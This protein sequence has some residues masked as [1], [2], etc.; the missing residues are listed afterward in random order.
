MSFYDIGQQTQ[1][2]LHPFVLDIFRFR[3]KDTSE[4]KTKGRH[5]VVINSATCCS[6]EGHEIT[7]EDP[8]CKSPPSLP[9]TLA[10]PV[11]HH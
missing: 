6:G 10:V 9:P 3:L 7:Q 4:D 1:S 11:W 2:K 8:T 5:S